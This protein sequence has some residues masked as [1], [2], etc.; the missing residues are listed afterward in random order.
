MENSFAIQ[1]N[2]ISTVKT[3]KEYESEIEA[4]KSENFELKHKLS[5]NSGIDSG[6]AIEENI[7]IIEVLKREKENNIMEF[8]K[9]L[10]IRN[11]K[12]NSYEEENQ[13]LIGYLEEINQKYKI[14]LNEINKYKNEIVKRD[15]DEKILKSKIEEERN[16]FR[17]LVQKENTMVIKL[18]RELEQNNKEL[19]NLNNRIKEYENILEETNNI[20]EKDSGYLRNEIIQRDE[21]INRY[22]QEIQSK[23]GIIEELYRNVEELKKNLKEIETDFEESERI[24]HNKNLEIKD[25]ENVLYDKEKKMEELVKMKDNGNKTEIRE[26]LEEINKIKIQIKQLTEENNNLNEIINNTH[27]E[28]EMNKKE[29]KNFYDENNRLKI[30]NNKL[31]EK[32]NNPDNLK[33]INEYLNVFQSYINKIDNIIDNQKDNVKLTKNNKRFIKDLKINNYNKVSEVLEEIR[34]IFNKLTRK[35]H[36]LENEIKEITFFA[37]NNKSILHDRTKKLLEEFTKEFNNARIEL[38]ECQKYLIRKGEENKTLKKEL[39]VLQRRVNTISG[40]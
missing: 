28:N 19:Q 27:K 25:L 6:K 12:I 5:M 15:N 33:R 34:N 39:K 29:M 31:I 26:Y 22:N 17:D 40:V 21:L 20:K 23:D 11:D 8:N 10:N 38:N 2:P 32:I 36:I 3:V 1:F 16:G 30:K 9:E 7:K 4:L 35:N 18:K 14:L 24:I 13:K 37:E